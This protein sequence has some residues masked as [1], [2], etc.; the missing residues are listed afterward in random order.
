MNIEL[1][2]A[3][4]KASQLSNEKQREIVALILDEISWDNSF[5]KSQNQLLILANEA[6]NEYKTSRTQPLDLD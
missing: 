2:I 6:L 3:I 4:E 1:K 5:E